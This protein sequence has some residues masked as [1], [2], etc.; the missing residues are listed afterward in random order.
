LTSSFDLK[1]QDEVFMIGNN[2]G[3]GYSV[4][5][6]R[7]V[8]LKLNRGDRHSAAFQTSFDRTGGSSGSPIF[9]VHGNV[10][11][12]RT[13]IFRLVPTEAV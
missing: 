6:G 7:V 4:K 12:L 11:G 13:L 5:Y 3:E 1:E 10:V 2:E 8:N 9:D